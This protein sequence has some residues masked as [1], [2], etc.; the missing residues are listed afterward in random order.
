MNTI[1]RLILLTIVAAMF[2][3]SLAQAA[4]GAQPGRADPVATLPV[5]GGWLSRG[6]KPCLSLGEHRPLATWNDPCVL[7]CDGKYVMYMTSSTMLP[8]RP[9]VQPFRAVSDDGVSWHLEPKT[10]LLAPGKEATAF[11]FQSVETPSVVTFKGKYHMYYTGVRT[12]LS[13]PMAIGHASSDD[14]IHW[15]KDAGNPVV[16]PTGKLSDFNGLQVAEPGA[17]VR[18]NEVLLYFTSVGLRPGGNP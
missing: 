4:Q 3:P 2:E 12:G 8:G 13:G 11:D 15:T 7:K 17:V 16:R 1:L 10:P 9:P 18:G 14:G 5:Q 6:E